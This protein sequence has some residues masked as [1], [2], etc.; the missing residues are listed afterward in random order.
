MLQSKRY[1]FQNGADHMAACFIIAEAVENT[2]CIRVPDRG[3]FSCHIRQ[4][5]N[6]IR[7][8]RDFFCL[9]CQLIKAQPVPELLPEPFQC[10]APAD[11][12]ALKQIHTGNNVRAEDQAFMGKSLIEANAHPTGLPALF[13]R[14]PGEVYSG[15]KCSAGGIQPSCHNRRSLFQPGEAGCFSG[16]SPNNLITWINFRYQTRINAQLG[17]K[18]PVHFYLV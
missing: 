3:T 13:L 8:C 12:T 15:A 10:S 4:K 18:S 16:N 14:L 1:A 2:L 5:D 9:G 6:S 17:S 11:R 7:S